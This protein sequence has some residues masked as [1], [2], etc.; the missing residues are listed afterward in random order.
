[1]D[2]SSEIFGI[3][4]YKQVIRFPYGASESGLTISWT[5][6]YPLV[7]LVLCNIIAVECSRLDLWLISCMYNREP[8]KTIPVITSFMLCN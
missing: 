3:G 4:T 7:V 1:M 6:L 2:L 5:D 8:Y